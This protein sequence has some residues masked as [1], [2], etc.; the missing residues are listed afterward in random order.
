MKIVLTSRAKHWE[1][2]LY[3]AI[4]CNCF[5]HCK[6]L[7]VSK[8]FNSLSFAC[9]GI[10][11]LFCL[12]LGAGSCSWMLFS[13]VTIF[14]FQILSFSCPLLFPF[15]ILIIQ[16][17]GHLN[18]FKF[19]FHCFH[20]I[21]CVASCAMS[22]YLPFILKHLLFEVD[23]ETLILAIKFLSQHSVSQVLSIGCFLPTLSKYSYIL[24]KY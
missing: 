5:F 12:K 21:F 20:L 9:I 16:L 22:S 18:I 3:A 11:F 14:F 17:S 23:T 1:S 10:G 6:S 19:I 2:R 24:L 8:C 4:R 13:S 15:E 7:I